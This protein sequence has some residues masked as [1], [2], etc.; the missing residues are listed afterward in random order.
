METRC[1]CGAFAIRVEDDGIAEMSHQERRWVVVNPA[2]EPQD[3]PT[4]ISST[5]CAVQFE[6]HWDNQQEHCLDVKRKVAASLVS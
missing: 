3:K 5:C 4:L 2:R 6:L 1:F